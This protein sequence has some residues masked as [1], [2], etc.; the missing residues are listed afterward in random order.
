MLPRIWPGIANREGRFDPSHLVSAF[1]DLVSAFGDADPWAGQ[2][3]RANVEPS[4]RYVLSLPGTTRHRPAP[5]RA[6]R[7]GARDSCHA[8]W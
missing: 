7:C 5:R 6:R 8:R 4:E 1:G 3:F 2:Y